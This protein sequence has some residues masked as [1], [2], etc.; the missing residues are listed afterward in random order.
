MTEYKTLF[1][2]IPN[3]GKLGIKQQYEQLFQ[4]YTVTAD[5]IL[6]QARPLS[7][8]AR[9]ELQSE[10]GKI[11]DALSGN[12]V[13]LYETT[14][15]GKQGR[16]AAATQVLEGLLSDNGKFGA[17]LQND[18]S[19]NEVFKSIEETLA[20]YRYVQNRI[21]SKPDSTL[22]KEYNEFRQKLDEA[23]ARYKANNIDT[24]VEETTKER[25]VTQ[26]EDDHGRKYSTWGKIMAAGSLAMFALGLTPSVTQANVYA[27]TPGQEQ[28][29]EEKKFGFPKDLEG[30]IIGPDEY[31]TQIY[32]SAT[33]PQGKTDPSER[34]ILKVEYSK[35]KTEAKVLLTKKAEKIEIKTDR[36]R[37]E[38][39]LT[40]AKVD[41]R[42]RVA[43]PDG[44]TKYVR[45]GEEFG[46]E[47]T[48]LDK[49]QYGIAYDIQVIKAE[50][51]NLLVMSYAASVAA[52]KVAPVKKIEGA[53]PKIVKPKPEEPKKEEKKAEKP[54]E[55]AYPK[56]VEPKKEEKKS[57]I[58]SIIPKASAETI[59]PEY[60][61]QL[62]GQAEEPRVG[63]IV[64]PIETI[65]DCAKEAYQ[66]GFVNIK[67]F[68]IVSEPIKAKTEK[69]VGKGFLGKF[70]SDKRGY[71]SLDDVLKNGVSDREKV[72]FTVNTEPEDLNAILDAFDNKYRTELVSTRQ[73]KGEYYELG[74][75]GA[76]PFGDTVF[77]INMPYR[78]TD[79]L[80]E[81]IA[82]RNAVTGKYEAVDVTLGGKGAI[83]VVDAD[84]WNYI[85]EKKKTDF[86]KTNKLV[87]N[88]LW[89]LVVRDKNPQIPDRVMVYHTGTDNDK[90]PDKT[91]I[92]CNAG[93]FV[94]FMKHAPG[95]F[96][97]GNGAGGVSDVGAAGH[98]SI[99]P[100]PNP[101]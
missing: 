34:T 49:A 42:I 43:L 54:A 37:K 33:N 22:V 26:T 69:K 29:T 55:I 81:S 3:F 23:K 47:G 48:K 18:A 9:Y 87:K 88:G 14:K 99:G 70:F 28:K 7:L 72:F 76:S 91:P 63:P 56:V 85:G 36:L 96:P 58:P 86:V 73:G 92:S 66:Q 98:N 80:V 52:K 93:D 67:K 30:K 71:P 68:A 25:T 59:A 77:E 13:R 45:I 12:T 27:Q 1:T 82:V 65:S 50:G 31:K 46:I 74:F 61:V 4:V 32:Y 16:F 17:L 79:Q 64:P 8:G 2:G 101:C 57:I 20:Q 75:K 6:E 15:K 90:L 35:D 11:T 60:K 97:G 84:Y 38:K 83:R 19:T 40:L 44:R 100:G 53:K 10:V 5:D 89:F 94:I 21:R 51:K 78:S 62:L 24:R 39:G 41:Y 95:T